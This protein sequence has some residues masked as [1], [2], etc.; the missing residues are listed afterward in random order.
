MGGGAVAVEFAIGDEQHCEARGL[1]QKRGGAM[2]RRGPCYWLS[3]YE[4]AVSGATRGNEEE[5]KE[6]ALCFPQCLLIHLVMHVNWGGKE[7]RMCGCAIV[8]MQ[9]TQVTSCIL[10]HLGERRTHSPSCAEF[11]SC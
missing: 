6:E 3:P 11:K 5:E 4:G 1:R 2:W 10:G 7:S 8:P 9:S